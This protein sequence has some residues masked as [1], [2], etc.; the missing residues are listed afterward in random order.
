M[1][2]LISYTFPE[3]C[4][5]ELMLH[6]HLCPCPAAGT[7][8]PCHPNHSNTS[9]AEW[10]PSYRATPNWIMWNREIQ[11]LHMVFCKG[12][13]RRGLCVHSKQDWL[14]K[15]T[16]QTKV[17]AELCALNVLSWGLQALLVKSP[18]TQFKVQLSSFLH[19]WQSLLLVC[20]LSQCPYLREFLYLEIIKYTSDELS[21]PS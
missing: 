5:P 16:I 15:R 11:E 17:M 13:I 8:L 12:V 20:Q 14:K 19:L 3:Q 6:S 1:L 18:T 4:I 9:H 10:S 7:A 21:L 2:Q